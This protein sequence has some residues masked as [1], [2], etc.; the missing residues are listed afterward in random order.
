MC[1]ARTRDLAERVHAGVGAARARDGRVT[2]DGKRG[3]RVFDERLNRRLPG[4]ALPA[5]KPCPVIG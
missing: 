1:D 2:I 3:Q 5:R 4:L